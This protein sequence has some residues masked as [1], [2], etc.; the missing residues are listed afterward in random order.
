MIWTRTTAAALITASIAAALTACTGPKVPESPSSI[1]RQAPTSTSPPVVPSSTR[2]TSPSTTS[3]ASPETVAIS[4]AKEVVRAYFQVS[5]ACMQDP[6]QTAA[7]C[8]DSVAISSALTDLRNG[9]GSAQAAQTRQIGSLRV[10]SIN[11][12]QVDLTNKPRAAPPT[13]PSVTVGVCY[14]VSKVD[15]VDHQGKSIVPPTR[16]SRAIENVTVVNYKYPDASS[17]R[18]GY[19]VPTDKSC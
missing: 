2:N 11:L 19:V 8:F 10:V 1:S 17:W 14:D 4:R 7:T 18:V 16:R 12:K 6:Q 9:L 13:I 15:I 5:D 3:S